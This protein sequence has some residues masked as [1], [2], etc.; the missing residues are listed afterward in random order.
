METSNFVEQG[1]EG[2]G[3]NK[4][5]AVFTGGGTALGTILGAVAGG[6]KGAA[7]GALSGAAAGVATQ[8]ITR[9]KGARIPA[10]TVMRFRLEAPVHVREMR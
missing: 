2:L 10:E 9:G 6:G 3:T 7:I 5:T 8:G 1:K 4:R